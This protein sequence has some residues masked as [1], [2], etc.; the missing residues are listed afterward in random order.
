M[1][2]VLVSIIIPVYNSEKYLT[3]TLNSALSQTWA[4][5]E[6]IIVDDGSTDNSL[7]LAKKYE[8]D[9]VKVFSQQNKG[10]S[11]ARN[12]G[13]KHANGTYIQFLDAD[14]LLSADKIASQVNILNN[15]QD[16]LC[17]CDTVHFNDNQDPYSLLVSTGWY[18]EESDD[19]VDFLLKLYSGGSELLPGYG[20]MIQPNCWLTP[21]HLIDKAGLWNEFRCPDDDGEF[22]CRVILAGKGVKF[23][24]TGVNYYRK[25]IKANSWSGQKSRQAFE[26]IFLSTDLKFGYLKNRTQSELLDQIFSRHYWEVG[27]ATYPK[28]KDISDKAIK[29]A[30]DLGYN[31]PK[32]VSG[33][34]STFLSKLLGW[35]IMRLLSYAKHGF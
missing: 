15:H 7:A 3:E 24:R 27:V 4:N 26:N 10:A 17:V 1:I 18:E 14:D 16:Y 25:H 9:N 5:K 13:L 12:L 34:T 32:Y 31:G 11:A 35:R 22:F 30:K 19:P 8:S 21:R 28:F 20:G 2:D 23:S 29:K 6:I 33:K